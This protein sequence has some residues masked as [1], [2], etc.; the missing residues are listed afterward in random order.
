MI[1][2]IKT[3]GKQY[4]V[5]KDSVISI[6]HIEGKPKKLVSFSDVLLVADKDGKLCTIG[7][8]F[9]RGKKVEGV[10][11]KQT[12]QKKIR[13]SKFKSKTRY[14]RIYGHRQMQ[15]IVKIKKI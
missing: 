6:E 5:S 12:R 4:L 15:T 2:I 9:I 10:I 7:T 11:I 14:S 3:G 1:A 8:P 13:V